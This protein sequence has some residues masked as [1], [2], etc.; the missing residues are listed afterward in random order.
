MSQHVAETKYT[1]RPAYVV[2]RMARGGFA[3]GNFSSCEILACSHAGSEGVAATALAYAAMNAMGT[4][5]SARTF[6]TPPK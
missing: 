1:V 2:L 4:T 3:T 6:I 5:H